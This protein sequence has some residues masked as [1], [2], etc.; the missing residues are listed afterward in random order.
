MVNLIDKSHLEHIRKFKVLFARY[1]RSRDLISVGAY[2]PGSDP[3]LDQAI[4]LYPRM[5]HFLQQELSEQSD[6]A[7]S[8]NALKLLF[9]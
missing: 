4:A 6:F 1:Q 2:I 9:L 8:L 5:E 3:V 7:A